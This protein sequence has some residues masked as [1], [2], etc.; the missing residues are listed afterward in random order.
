MAHEDSPSHLQSFTTW[1]EAERRLMNGKGID[2]KIEDQIQTEKQQGRD[3]LKRVL[4]CIKFIA[5]RNLA[6]RG[7][8]ESL[9][10]EVNNKIHSPQRL[11]LKVLFFY[12]MFTIF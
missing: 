9:T 5:S 8:N 4:S 6:L 1:K 3:I 7:H 10:D 11:E 12:W 2:A